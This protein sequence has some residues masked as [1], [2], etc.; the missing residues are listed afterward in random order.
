MEAMD[1]RRFAA[2]CLTVV[3]RPGRAAALGSFAAALAV[4]VGGVAMA[5]R[6]YPGDFD[7]IYTVL[8]HLAS[9][10]R[11][12]DGGRWLSGAF[13]V[14]VVLLWPAVTRLGQSGPG[15][16]RGLCAAAVSLRAGLLGGA[17]LGL[18]GVTGLRFSEYLHKLHEAIA[19]LTFLAFYGGVLGLYGVRARASRGFWLPAALIVLPILA[20]GAAQ[21]SLYFDQR[22]LGWVNTDWRAQGVPLWMSFAFWQWTAAVCLAF[23]LGFLVYTAKETASGGTDGGGEAGSVRVD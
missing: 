7:W 6:G 21:I 3:R 22:D 12:P 10:R 13:V 16:R 5:V 8:S 4:V 20:I 14:A 18:E 1:G 2:G 9:T 11:N 23:G 17:L 19:L 15:G